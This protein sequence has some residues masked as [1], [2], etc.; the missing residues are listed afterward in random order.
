MSGLGSRF[1]TEQA[2]K[3]QKALGDSLRARSAEE[4]AGFTSAMRGTP[5]RSVAPLTPN[6]DEGN[7]MAAAVTPGVAPDRSKAL[8]MALQSALREQGGLWFGSITLSRG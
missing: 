7:P 8:A 4:I 3:K 5:E 1:A 6:D 2:D